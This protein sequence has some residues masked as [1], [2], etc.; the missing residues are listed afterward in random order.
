MEFYTQAQEIVDE[1]LVTL[2]MI[3]KF[4]EFKQCLWE[5]IKQFQD[6]SCETLNTTLACQI[7]IHILTKNETVH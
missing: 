3:Y 7:V 2:L 5:S 4:S 1:Q 6:F